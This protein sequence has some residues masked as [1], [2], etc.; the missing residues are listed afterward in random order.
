MGLV[1]ANL[2]IPVAKKVYV[3][4]DV[5]RDPDSGK[6]SILNLWDTI[7]VPSSGFPHTQAKV[8]VFAQLRGGWGDIPVHV[9]IMHADSDEL[10]RKVGP[11]AVSFRDRSLTYRV[12]C[13]IEG[14]VFQGP[15]VYVVELYCDQ[16]FVDDQTFRVISPDA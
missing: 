8:C 12:R 15:G 10:L 1:M 9:E 2:I 7:R 3:C 13:Q 4:D 6:V 5:I 11:F 14:V 16:Q